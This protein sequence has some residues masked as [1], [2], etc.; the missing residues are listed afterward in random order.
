MLNRLPKFYLSDGGELTSSQVLCFPVSLPSAACG[1]QVSE[2][3]F[4]LD[5][6]VILVIRGD[7]LIVP[8]A[9]TR[10]TAGDHVYSL[11][12]PGDES[13]LYLIFGRPE[14]NLHKKGFGLVV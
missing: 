13:L 1:A 5:S 6:A 2:L 8:T 14:A 11:V 10:L 9:L 12:R 7:E 4:L 3:S